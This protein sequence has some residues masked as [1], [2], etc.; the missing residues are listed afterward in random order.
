MEKYPGDIKTYLIVHLYWDIAKYKRTA[1]KK[2]KGKIKNIV[3]DNAG[4]V[5]LRLLRLSKYLRIAE[6]YDFQVK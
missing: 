2:K 5:I 1:K 4:F 6:Y 3:G